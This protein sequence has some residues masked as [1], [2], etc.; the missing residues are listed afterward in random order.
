MFFFYFKFISKLKK[1]ESILPLKLVNKHQ[2][3]CENFT[4]FNVKNHLFL[5]KFSHYKSSR[6]SYNNSTMDKTTIEKIAEI[7]NKFLELKSLKDRCTTRVP[8]L[9]AFCEKLNRKIKAIKKIEKI[10][11]IEENGKEKKKENLFEQNK[12]LKENL[13][14]CF[15]SPDF[16]QNKLRLV[17]Y[18]INT[19]GGIQEIKEDEKSG[20]KHSRKKLIF[21]DIAS[22]K[23]PSAEQSTDQVKEMRISG[24]YISSRSKVLSF[25]NPEEYVICDS[26]VIFSLNWLLFIT[27]TK[28]RTKEQFV[29]FSKLEPRNKTC[30]AYSLS[31]LL[32]K[33][34]L[35]PAEEKTQYKEFIEVI[36]ALTDELKKKQGN[37][38]EIYCTE[39]LLFQIA[40]DLEYGI[41]CLVREFLLNK[42]A[43]KKFSSKNAIELLKSKK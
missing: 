7:L 19:W 12:L 3:N 38:W 10:E 9:P 27:R 16:E 37:A 21:D 43:V 41:P 34:N 35:Q 29:Q 25:L 36:K 39:M 32:E 13:K 5:W 26:R 20:E 2:I 17:N 6:T 30:K 31:Y 42:D 24:D 18:I 28:T 23:Q 4:D 40:D 33:Y 22:V 8:E 14:E 1:V 11:K 15:N